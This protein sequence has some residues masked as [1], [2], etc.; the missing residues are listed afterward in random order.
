MVR[1]KCWLIQPMVEAPKGTR[2]V[3][4]MMSTKRLK[5]PGLASK[6]RLHTWTQSVPPR[7]S[8]W[9]DDQQC[10]IAN[11]FEFAALTHPLPRC[12]TDRVQQRFRTF[13]AK[14]SVQFFSRMTTC[15]ATSKCFQ[16]L[17]LFFI[18]KHLRLRR[19]S[20]IT[21]GWPCFDRVLMIDYEQE[22]SRND[23]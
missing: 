6:V 11:D 9:V 18:G 21:Q 1:Q 4:L 16:G 17:N 14:P 7:G 22:I 19:D 12:G 13:E 5:R 2:R 8:G 23:G 15:G 10:N 20:H 3:S